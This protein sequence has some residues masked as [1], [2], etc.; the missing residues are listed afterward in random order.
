MSQINATSKEITFTPY[1]TTK[2]NSQVMLNQTTHPRTL[3]IEY[4]GASDPQDNLTIT[5]VT[6]I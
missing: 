4:V 1:K 3:T 6:W 5:A 2:N